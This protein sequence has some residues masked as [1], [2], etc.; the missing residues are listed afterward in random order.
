MAQ[1]INFA[2]AF[3]PSLSQDHIPEKI[4]EKVHTFSGSEERVTSTSKRCAIFLEAALKAENRQGET[5]KH[6]EFKC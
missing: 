6:I 2:R 4:I 3:L 5:H 1:L